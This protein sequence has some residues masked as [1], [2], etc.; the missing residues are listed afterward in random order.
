[1]RLTTTP[2]PPRSPAVP[3]ARVDRDH[4][5]HGEIV[6]V[7]PTGVGRHLALQH[8]GVALVARLQLDHD[9]GE[10]RIHLKHFPAPSSPPATTP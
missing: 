2:T 9:Q 7:V 3:P 6:L 5:V 10:G 8:G 1:M 4:G